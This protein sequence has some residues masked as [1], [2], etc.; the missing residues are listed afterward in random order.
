MDLSCHCRY[1]FDATSYVYCLF[2]CRTRESYSNFYTNPCLELECLNV[3]ERISQYLP[4]NTIFTAQGAPGRKKIR[5]L[6]QTSV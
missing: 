1:N 2:Y 6:T 3:S 4:E 5:A